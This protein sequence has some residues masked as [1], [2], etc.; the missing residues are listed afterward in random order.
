[1]GKHEHTFRQSW[2]KTASTCPERARREHAG[3]LPRQ[4]SDAAAVG[5]AVHA[6][7]EAVLN[8]EVTTYQEAL[9]IAESTFAE[10]EQHPSFVW[11]KYS[12][13]VASGLIDTFLSHWWAERHTFSP[14]GTEINF[15][16]KFHEDDERIIWFSGTMDYLDAAKGLFDWKTSGRGPYEKW[17]YERWAIQPTVYTWA[18]HSDDAE[19]GQEFPFS[20][21]V[22]HKNGMQQFTVYRSDKDWNWLK[23][24]V[25][26]YAKLIEADLK[27]WPKNDT[28]ALCSAKWCPAWDTCKGSH[29]LTPSL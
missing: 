26:G 2:L 13:N 1:M 6:A 12:H 7:I 21:A 11:S 17:E 22:M 5:T 25:V 27:E 9:E 19:P 3:E 4:E 10:I 15:K 29:F 24:L 20:Y 18:H 23:D 16:K 8:D 14:V 28:H